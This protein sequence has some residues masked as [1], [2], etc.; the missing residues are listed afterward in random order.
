M[1]K[2]KDKKAT[3]KRRAK[4]KHEKEKKRH[5][6]LVKEKQKSLPPPPSLMTRPSFADME[7]PDGF[8]TVSVSQALMEF[9]KPLMGDAEGSTKALNEVFEVVNGIWNYE[10]MLKDEATGKLEEMKD[11]MIRKMKSL[12]KIQNDEAEGLLQE[13][14]D[15]KQHL[16]PDEIQPEI[17]TVMFMRKGL[18]HLIAPFNYTGM[19][20]SEKTIPPDEHDKEVLKKIKKIDRHIIDG[21][22]YDEWEEFYFS[23]EES[24]S[25]AFEKWLKEKGSTEQSQT[26]ASNVELF[27][28]FIYRYAHEDLVILDAVQP[29]YFEEFLFDYLLRKLIAEPHEYVTFPPT[30]K[31]F[32]RFLH[33]KGYLPNPEDVIHVID[34][35]EPEFIDVLRER[36]G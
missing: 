10:I 12:L 36:F 28:N 26:F 6:K 16:F 13:M 19:S 20:F 21:T 35:L 11:T 9:G 2:K 25:D 30:L 18:S 5:L 33:E 15:R 23:M 17:P 4:S 7:A 3:E 34:A 27:L 14:I 24:V 29:A 22:D 1:A 32:F 31:F 8:R